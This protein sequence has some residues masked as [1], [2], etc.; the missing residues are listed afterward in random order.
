MLLPAPVVAA[1]LIGAGLHAAWNVAVRAGRDRRREV[2]LVLGGAALL[3]AAA[4]PA[5]PPVHAAARPF[6]I[7]SAVLHV[8]YF[9]L[10]AEAYVHGGVS[11]A[12]PLMRG[13]APM[14]TT[15]VAWGF[16]HELLPPAAWIGIFGI[17]I[18][19]VVLARRRGE[20]GEKTATIVSLVNA[21]VIAAYTLNDAEGA[22]ASGSPVAYTLWI[23]LLT[24]A[25]SMAWLQRG[26]WGR[27][28]TAREVLRG[29]GGGAC[30][31]G[32]YALAVWAL[33]HAPVAPVAALRETS[34][35]FGVVLA[36]V[37]LGERP[38]FRGWAGAAIIACGAAILRLA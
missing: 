23:F 22:R 31:T 2:V 36:R 5:L 24:A 35:L 11:L 16:L 33:A 4:L 18:G 14:L 9:A 12:Y 27:W 6:L 10:V 3:A 15:I 13:T 29:L 26:R 38:G 37:V 21:V 28:P 1:V 25:P 7:A 34:M 30:T 19:V 32:S 20:P 17:C 8:G